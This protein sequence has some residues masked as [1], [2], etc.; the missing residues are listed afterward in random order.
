MILLVAYCVYLNKIF[1]PT[2][3][4]YLNFLSIGF[5]VIFVIVLLFLMYWLFFSWRHFLT[6]FILS[7]G[8][9][10]PIYLSYPLIQFNKTDNSTS[11]LSVLSYNVHGFKEEGT[12]ELL[13]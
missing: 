1:T 10:Y 13:I 11:D 7:L 12:K 8:L 4:P 5:P 6:F 2:E 9:V 3:I